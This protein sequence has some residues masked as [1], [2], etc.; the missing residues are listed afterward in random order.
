MLSGAQNIPVFWVLGPLFHDL[1]GVLYLGLSH[2]L[3]L[4][5]DFLGASPNPAR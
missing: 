2:L 1:I 4:P 3:T 5:T